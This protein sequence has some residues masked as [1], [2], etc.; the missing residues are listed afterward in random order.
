M[1]I[2]VILIIDLLHGGS[3]SIHWTDS[4]CAE[5]EEV[6]EVLLDFHSK[7]PEIGKT[8]RYIFCEDKVLNYKYKI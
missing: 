8:K 5:P 6:Q 1:K 4:E 2:I 3:H 7:H